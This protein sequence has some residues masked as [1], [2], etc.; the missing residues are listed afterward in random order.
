MRGSDDARVTW[1][2]WHCDTG[3][4]EADETAVQVP[5]REWSVQHAD[6]LVGDAGVPTGRRQPATALRRR[7]SCSDGPRR[8]P[9]GQ[10]ESSSQETDAI[11][12]GLSGTVAGLL[13][14]RSAHWCVVSCYISVCE[15][16][17]N[18]DTMSEK[19]SRTL[20]IF[21]HNFINTALISIALDTVDMENL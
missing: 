21:R 16:N 10:G 13:R 19:K 12:S 7:V 17:T 3:G 18:N 14:L 20:M 9:T 5:R 11:G 6:M 4:E 2:M 1:P 8:Q 15:F